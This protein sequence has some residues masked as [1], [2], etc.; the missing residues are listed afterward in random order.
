MVSQRRIDQS[1][2]L[3]AAELYEIQLPVSKSVL[4][5]AMTVSCDSEANAFDPLSHGPVAIPDNQNEHE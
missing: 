1:A 4:C 5:V 2:S 3:A